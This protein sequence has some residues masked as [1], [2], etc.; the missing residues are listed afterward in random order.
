MAPRAESLPLA[1]VPNG[2]QSDPSVRFEARGAGFGVQ[3]TDRHATF[4]LERGDRGQALRLRF[5][6]A[7]RRPVVEGADPLPGAEKK[8]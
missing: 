5:L 1:F 6:G 3:L 8:K 2:G 4:A 7:N